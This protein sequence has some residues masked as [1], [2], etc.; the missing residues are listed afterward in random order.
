[1]KHYQGGSRGEVPPKP[2]REIKEIAHSQFSVF[3]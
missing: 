3:P 1:M 2:K